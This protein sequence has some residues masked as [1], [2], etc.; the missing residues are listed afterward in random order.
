M[1]VSDEASRDGALLEQLGS[2]FDLVLE[3]VSGY[4]G[5]LDSLREELRGQ[6][7][8]IGRQIRFLSEQIAINRANLA[9]VKQD[10]SAE[11]GRL[12]EE[13]GK[14]RIEM[15]E[16]L[17]SAE[18]RL[19]VEIG[20]AR[21]AIEGEGAALRE[22]IGRESAQVAAKVRPAS[23]TGAAIIKKLEAELKRAAK[24][25]AALDKKFDR[26]D[27]RVTIQTRDQEQR[28]RKLERRA[29]G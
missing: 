3:A 5:R 20:A 9:G 23:D 12:G 10:L 8:E 22:Q 15:T 27:D 11:I 18:A 16:R 29:R 21:T 17:T 2:R 25:L 4:G 13:L 24:M 19:R 28:V 26:F 1:D 14:A 6:F 7:T